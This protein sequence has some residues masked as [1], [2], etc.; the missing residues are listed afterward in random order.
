MAARLQK[1]AQAPVYDFEQSIQNKVLNFVKSELSDV[2]NFAKSIATGTPLPNGKSILPSPNVPTAPPKPPGLNQNTIQTGPLNPVEISGWYKVT[3]ETEATFY[4]ITDWP[5]TPIGKGW[6][7]DQL[8]GLRGQLVMIEASNKPGKDVAPYNWSFTF[9]TDMDQSI[10][11]VQFV[12][13]T[14][15]YPPGRKSVLRSAPIYG[16]YVVYRNVPSFYF[17]VP[18]PPGTGAGWIIEGLPTLGP[19]KLL[20]FEQNI[21]PGVDEAG[22][23]LP[24]VT[25]STCEPVDGSFPPNAGPVYVKGTPSLIHEPEPSLTFTPGKFYS[26]P[27]STEK[28]ILNPN[29]VSVKAAPLRDL[30]EGLGFFLD[31][32]DK[33]LE[34]KGRGFS[35]GSVLS[36]FAIGPQEEYLLTDDT[37]KSQWNPEYKQHSNF[38]MYQRTIPLA[39]PNPYYQGSIIQVELRPTELGHL[40]SNMYLKCTLPA[41]PAG[42]RYSPQGGRALIQKVDLLVNETV[43]ETL[44]DDW[45]VIRDQLFLDADETYAIQNA[46]G[47]Y[48]SGGGGASSNL[49]AGSDVI[50]PLEF[51]FCRRHSANNKARERLK[52]PYFPLCA[53]WN[54]KLYVRFT[55]QPSSWWATTSVTSSNTIVDILNPKLITEEIL[56]EDGEK[57]YYQNTPLKY[58]VNRVSKEAGINF[59]ASNPIVNLTATYP[60]ALM[61]W[62][63]RNRLYEN[64]SNVYAD[65]RYNY[66]YT[67]R[68]ITTGINLQFP[69]S[70]PNQGQ[71]VDVIQT[72]KITLNN[73]D[74]LSNFQG[75]LYYSFQQPMEH[76]LSIP[77]LN[78]YT[79]SFGL[80]PTEYNQGGYLNFSKLNSQTTTLSLVFNP[81]YAQQTAGGYNLYV[82]YYGYTLLQFQ[83]GFASLPNL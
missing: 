70:A 64:S 62:F 77:S 25:V 83:G 43:I 82:F 11:G 10:D 1:I 80:N 32:P 40:L 37:T 59:S 31:P 38:V 28:V 23:K 49:A 66:G 3:K 52:K 76:R 57:L 13:T 55:F 51:F 4:S 30:N 42:G 7:V 44:Y 63:F 21:S 56:L 2:L 16:Y 19:L 73:I 17:S 27:V 9:Q 69:S 75:S 45:Y 46:L 24:P 50:I 74:I 14:S 53:M 79:Y 61:T 39:P 72:A 18:P 41:L 20:D 22:N 15:L 81:S 26:T 48:N 6:L 33:Y 34:S 47:T 54:Q 35:Q 36:L 71:F 65:S 5:F 78:I 60:V 29:L 8:P 58:I 12:T 68:Y 67:N